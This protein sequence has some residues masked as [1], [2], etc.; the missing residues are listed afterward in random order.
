M[1]IFKLDGFPDRK[2][3]GG[4]HVSWLR[5]LKMNINNSITLWV[6]NAFYCSFRVAEADNCLW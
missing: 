4:M 6:D 5:C 2:R 3:G 1:W